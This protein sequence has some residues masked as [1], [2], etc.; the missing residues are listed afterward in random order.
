MGDTP[1]DRATR[2]ATDADGEP[3]TFEELELAGGTDREVSLIATRDDSLIRRLRVFPRDWR[4]LSDVDLL[5]LVG[6]P[7]PGERRAE[8]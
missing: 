5:R 4:R 8:A 6:A 3:W 2:T 1:R 7:V